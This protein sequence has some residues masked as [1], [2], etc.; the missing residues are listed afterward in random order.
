MRSLRALYS[1]LFASLVSQLQLPGVGIPFALK[2]PFA[3]GTIL[4]KKLADLIVPA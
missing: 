1:V 4:E 2:V 3:D